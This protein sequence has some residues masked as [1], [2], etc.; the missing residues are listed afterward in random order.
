MS[1]SLP[2]DC[3][4]IICSRILG[5]SKGNEQ[6]RRIELLVEVSN[7]CRAPFSKPSSWS[8]FCKVEAKDWVPELRNPWDPS[9]ELMEGRGTRTIVRNERVRQSQGKLIRRF[10]QSEAGSGQMWANLEAEG[11]G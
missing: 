4:D 5:S 9:R 6:I 8:A 10:K 2:S 3:F 1:S 7:I 11:I